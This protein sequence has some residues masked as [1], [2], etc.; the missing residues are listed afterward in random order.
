V[1]CVD[2]PLVFERAID[3]HVLAYYSVSIEFCNNGTVR[4]IILNYSGTSAYSITHSIYSPTV[5][6]FEFFN[7]FHFLV[8]H[9]AFC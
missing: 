4:V 8:H 9:Y 5:T 1:R 6:H 3:V 7:H 2:Y